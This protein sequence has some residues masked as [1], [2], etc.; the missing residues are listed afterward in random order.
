[1]IANG[2]RLFREGAV[3]EDELFLQLFRSGAGSAYTT[4]DRLPEELR[5]GVELLKVERPS[6]EAEIP[7]ERLATACFPTLVIS[8]GHS[9][10]LQRARDGVAAAGSAAR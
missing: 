1:M 2:E 4:P 7:V 9:P 5:L 8:G 3:L 10:A 6:W